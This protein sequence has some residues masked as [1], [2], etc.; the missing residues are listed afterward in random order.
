MKPVMVDCGN[1]VRTDTYASHLILFQFFQLSRVP[2]K[3]CQ[4]Y[5]G[6]SPSSRTQSPLAQLWIDTWMLGHGR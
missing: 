4:I 6:S 1:R 5:W 3:V 2:L